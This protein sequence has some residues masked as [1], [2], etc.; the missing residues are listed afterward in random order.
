VS[1]A[2]TAGP[3]DAAVGARHASDVGSASSGLGDP[4]DRG[5]LTVADRVVERV[6]GY[7][8]T[9]VEG[10]SAAPRRMLGVAVGGARPDQEASVDARVDGSTATVDASVAIGWPASVRAVTAQ[11]R[12]RVREDVERMTGV[13][14]AHIDI[15]VVS[16]R[17]PSAQPRRVQ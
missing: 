4:A 11:L 12:Q 3:D 1:T 14:V 10:A 7:A 6:A 2:V 17:V 8:V 13:R 15:D 5:R 9:L 16:L